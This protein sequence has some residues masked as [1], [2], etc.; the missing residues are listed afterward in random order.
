LTAAAADRSLD[1]GCV[2]IVRPA[3]PDAVA[4]HPDASPGAA[5]ADGRTAPVARDD[6]RRAVTLLLA[7]AI[8][9]GVGLRLK[10]YFARH[11]Y[12]HDEAS[13]V[14]NIFEKNAKQLLGPLDLAQA[15]APGFLLL[16]RG[17]YVLLGRSELAM[18]LP[19]LLASLAGIAIF[20]WLAWRLLASGNERG[21]SRIALLV[22]VLW[23]CAERLI[24][25]AAEAKQYSID[26]L[27][28][29]TLLAVALREDRNETARLVTCAAIAAVAVWFSHATAFVFGGVSLALLPAMIRSQRGR[30]MVT[31]MAANALFGVSFLALYFAS[32]RNQQVNALYEYWAAG[33][34]DFSKPWII[35]VWMFRGMMGIAN[36]AL[37]LGGPVLLPLAALGAYVLWVHGRRQVLGVLVMPAVLVLVAS[38]IR[39]YPFNGS[40][41][42]LF[43]TPN[44]FLLA[45]VGVVALIEWTGGHPKWKWLAVAVPGYLLAVAAWWAIVYLVRPPI[46]GNMPAAVRYV[47]AHDA[48]QDV[49]YANKI[50]EFRCYWPDAQQ[51]QLRDAKELDTHVPD[52]RFWLVLSYR[53]EKAIEEFV[54]DASRQAQQL[55]AFKVTGGAAM[56]FDGT[57]GPSSRPSAFA[58]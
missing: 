17:V 48:P 42:T 52:G 45:G 2:A 3:V 40:R 29:L 33:F 57:N 39:Q 50:S 49:I 56:L 5:A 13:L 11:A 4:A 43:L 28:A 16:E 26:V 36:Y 12:W 10:H 19:P 55:D 31:W 24:W 9:L 30:G 35:P 46:Y 6:A 23:S 18:R 41:L 22:I 34:V 58:N 37:D 21:G 53:K 27:V 25:H 14:L 7:A 44:V 51:H 1:N 47:A 20:S 32:V 54:D 8:L 15:A 38:A